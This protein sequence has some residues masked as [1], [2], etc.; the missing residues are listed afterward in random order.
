MAPVAGRLMPRSLRPLAAELA[1]RSGRAQ[2]RV[3]HM[4]SEEER[5]RS[6]AVGN[7]PHWHYFSTSGAAFQYLVELTS[8]RGPAARI[9]VLRRFDCAQLRSR[10]TANSP[11]RERY[12]QELHALVAHALSHDQAMRPLVEQH[13]GRGRIRR[14]RHNAGAQR[15]PR[16]PADTKGGYCE[17]I[18]AGRDEDGTGAHANARECATSRRPS[19]SGN[20]WLTIEV[21]ARV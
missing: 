10:I 18:S 11:F 20:R 14:A 4:V 7:G 17:S 21:S 5:Q 12:R 8:R 6:A 9:V 16:L 13:R 2:G 15:R 1:A 19:S 3:L